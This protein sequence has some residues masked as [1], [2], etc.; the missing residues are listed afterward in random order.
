M[1]T[2]KQAG[3]KLT[4]AQEIRGNATPPSPV[5]TPSLFPGTPNKKEETVK[6]GVVTQWCP[7]PIPLLPTRGRH[8]STS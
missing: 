1:N 2:S 6:A 3:G 5:E 7:Q 4:H 8:K